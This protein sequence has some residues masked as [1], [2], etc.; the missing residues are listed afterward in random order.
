MPGI[1]VR[2]RTQVGTWRLSDVQS[3][4]TMEMLRSRVEKE[5]KTDLE[6]RPF[7][8]DPGG[9]E[10]VMDDCTVADLKMT[11]GQIL[12]AQ[13]DETKT[14][15]H[16]MATT[17]KMIA[18][19]GSIVAQE[20]EDVVARTGFRPGMM[21]LRDM[22]MQWRLDEFVA[23]DSQFEYKLKRQ[24][25]AMAAGVQVDTK[26]MQDFQAYCLST[27]DFQQMRV[28]YLYGTI[29][30]ATGIE[31]PK[32]KEEVGGSGGGGS[33]SSSPQKEHVWGTKSKT[34]SGETRIA[35][36]SSSSSSGDAMDTEEKEKQ[37]FEDSGEL[38]SVRV[39]FIYE[40]PQSNTDTSFE[41]EE[42]PLA[43]VVDKLA[44]N[45]GLTKV[46]WIFAHPPREEKFHFNSA[47]I[48][49]AAEQQLLAAEGISDTPFVTVKVTLDP[50]TNLPIAE[51]F[52]VSKQAMEMA[53]EGAL[54]IHPVH[55]GSCGVKDTFTA[56]VE[57]KPTKEIENDFFLINLPIA[58]YES[59]TFLSDFPRLNRMGNMQS[60]EDLKKQLNRAGKQGWTFEALLADFQLLL[61]LTQ[62]LDANHD[63]PMI[64]KSILDKAIP[65][66]EGHMLIIRSL[67]GL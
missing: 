65:L 27:L 24:E 47:E 58:G 38:P 32:K 9:K 29:L 55:P 11:N 20:Y 46:G 5:H 15:V 28:G 59:E 4:D 23:L 43:E 14:G 3:S 6:G 41:L 1:V 56:Y 22:K 19:D 35:S 54:T 31:K 60:R 66:D 40:P 51:G 64:C 21:P 16:E 2:V 17:G 57:H 34:V 8:S 26:S 53:A 45:L 49:E 62:F 48:I 37:N 42:D 18:K 39:E 30:P 7:T 36:N 52:Q 44:A 63:L 67:A 10:V 13:V 61:F 50:K 12:Y 25:K 33:S